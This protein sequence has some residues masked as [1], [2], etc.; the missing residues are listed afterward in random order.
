MSK[1]TIHLDNGIV[2][3]ISFVTNFGVHFDLANARAS[4]KLASPHYWSVIIP[5]SLY[6][7]MVNKWNEYG[8]KVTG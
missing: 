1:V 2:T 4:K 8:K 6:E 7:I 5:I 3:Q